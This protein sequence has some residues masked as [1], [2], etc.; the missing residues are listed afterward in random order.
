MSTR[1]PANSQLAGNF[2]PFRD[3]FANDCPLQRRVNKLS[4]PLTT[5]PVVRSHDPFAVER[6]VGRKGS[7]RQS[8]A[9]DGS[10]GVAHQPSSGGSGRSAPGRRLAAQRSLSA[11]ERRQGQKRTQSGDG[12]V[13]GQERPLELP[14][15]QLPEPSRRR[16]ARPWLRGKP[17]GRAPRG[18]SASPCRRQVWFAPEPQLLTVEETDR[19]LEKTVNY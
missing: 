4:V 7:D 15:C 1:F 16:A 17:R 13:S 14:P 2:C 18:P 3:R 11:G 12:H 6:P 8:A 9:S 10:L 5:A 19:A